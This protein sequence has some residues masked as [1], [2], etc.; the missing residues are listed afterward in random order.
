MLRGNRGALVSRFFCSTLAFLAT[1]F[2]VTYFC[3]MR[4]IL[5][6]KAWLSS[7]IP[8]NVLKLVVG[9]IFLSLVARVSFPIPGHEIPVTLQTFGIL[10]LALISGWRLALATTLLY[11]IAG[12]L[13]APVF[14]SGR[15]GWEHLVGPSAGFFLGFLLSAFWAGYR[16]DNNLQRKFPFYLSEMV[17]GHFLILFSGLIGLF[18]MG[19]SGADLGHLLLNFVPGILVKVAL[20]TLTLE[21]LDR[22][23]RGR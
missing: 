11:L 1:L 22:L 14:S 4:P 7:P 20:G 13:G 9:V 15:S 16:T 18:L 5:F 6:R 23:T 3:S 19:K 8:D 2:P 12:G 17:A 10:F 21:G